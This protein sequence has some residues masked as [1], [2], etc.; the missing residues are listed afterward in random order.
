VLEIGGIAD[1]EFELTALQDLVK[2][3][4]PGVNSAYESVHDVVVRCI[5]SASI[6]YGEDEARKWAQGFECDSIKLV[7]DQAAFEAA[8]FKIATMAVMRQNELR[9]QRLNL[10]RLLLLSEDNPERGHLHSL[11]GGI[12]VP[13]PEGYRPNAKCFREIK[14]VLLLQ[15][16]FCHWSNCTHRSKPLI[17]WKMF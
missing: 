7:N 10:D 2:E 1:E 3:I 11:C 8:D 5:K 17:P 13:K 14:E 16:I 9:S 12:I 6:I 15:K 4:K